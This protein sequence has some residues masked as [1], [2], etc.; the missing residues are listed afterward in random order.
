MDFNIETI[1]NYRIAYVRKVGP[2][3]PDNVQVMGQLKKWAAE[4]KL[5]TESA[6]ILGI[7]Q[8]NP[9]TTLPEHCR[10]DAGIV[11]PADAQMDDSIQT[12]EFSGGVY[13]AFQIP[14]TAEAIEEAWVKIIPT[15]VHSGHS[16]DNRP[17]VERYSGYMISNHECEICV[18]VRK[19]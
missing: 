3:G 17:M 4:S 8:D 18:P 12:S 1:P 6:I 9:E 10:Y 11:I 7:L 15:L 2:Y 16:I 19:T 5:L 13:A 14:H